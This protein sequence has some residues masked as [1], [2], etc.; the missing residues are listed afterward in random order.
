M[1]VGPMALPLLVRFA[2]VVRA[3]FLIAVCIAAMPL[4][5]QSRV[6]VDP[7]VRQ[8]LDDD[9]RA[10]FFILLP[11]AADLAAAPRQSGK[12]GKGQWVFETLRRHAQTAQSDLRSFL[13][14]HGVT[15][16][17]FLIAN[18]IHIQNG[19][20]A[21]V[22]ML[23]AR[24][25]IH[26]LLPDRSHRAERIVA[27]RESPQSTRGVEPN[28]KFIKVDQVWALGVEGSGIVLA[29]I[30][31]GMQWDH[32]A[33]REQYR[34]WNGHSADHN[35]HWWD[36]T[37]TYPLVPS[38]GVADGHGT[39]ITGTMVGRDRYGNQV[40]MAP[41]AKTIHCKAIAD[42]GLISEAWLLTCL[43]FMLAPWDLSGNAPRPDLAPDILGNSWGTTSAN[44]MFQQA[45][46]ALRSAG[47]LV[48]HSA[49]DLGPGCNSVDSPAGYGNVISTG[50][51]D[52]RNG[53][54]PG[55][56]SVFSS[57]GPSVLYP[58]AYFPSVVAPGEGIRSTYPGNGF[59]MR[60]GTGMAGA[61]VAGLAGL[62]W[63]ANPSLRGNIALTEQLI[64]DTAAPLTGQ[65][66][67]GCGGDYIDGPNHDWGHGAIDALA[68][69]QA[70][71]AIDGRPGTV[72][73]V[74]TDAG[75][76]APIS[77]ATVSLGTFEVQT[78]Q[79]GRYRL[80]RAPG[81]YA[82]T[83]RRG[84]YI[85]DGIDAL[86]IAS[87]ETVVHDLALQGA[88]LT[89]APSSMDQTVAPGAVMKRQMTL[90][91][92]GPAPLEFALRLRRGPGAGA[93]AVSLDA[94]EAWGLYTMPGTSAMTMFVQFLD[95]GRPDWWSDH[96]ALYGRYLGGT[97]A[98]PNLTWFY[99]MAS[100]DRLRLIHV[101]TSTVTDV[102]TAVPLGQNA[103]WTSLS[104]SPN[105][106]LY[107]LAVSQPNGIGMSTLYT[108]SA[109]DGSASRVGDIPASELTGMAFDADGTL[110]A[111]G[112]GRL[113][114][115]DP[116]TA[117]ATL[118]GPIGTTPHHGHGPLAVNQ[119][120]GQ[121]YQAAY[122]D[123]GRLLALDKATGEATYAGSLPR[124]AKF[125]AISFA[126]DG[127]G[128][129]A[130][131][132]PRTGTIPPGG[133]TTV[134]VRLDATRVPHASIYWATLNAEGA[135]ANTPTPIPL[136]MR[137]GC[138]AC[139]TVGGRVTDATTGH[140]VVASLH[141]DD[142]TTSLTTIGS[143]YAVN[144]P[145]G[146]YAVVATAAGYVHHNGMATI[147]MGDS[148]T[149]DIPLV[150]AERLFADG[151]DSTPPH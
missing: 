36:A 67:S 33:L 41:R 26:A 13:D 85:D 80:T 95:I 109:G 127:I 8:A 35:H 44:P 37:G 130:S 46:A 16:R 96:F 123:S 68:A 11:A 58:S 51:V 107:A 149:T 91:N 34:G 148:S 135:F 57:R 114:T 69:V 10:N 62:M 146:N 27:D 88:A 101:P 23:S 74:V 151:F 14:T 21:L 17:P 126:N 84:G 142:G 19:D 65:T 120:T 110:Y 141:F 24:T 81:T 140:P 125:E 52:H 115:L 70:A 118:I 119:A 43:E 2:W 82:L 93:A 55:V 20:A 94:G 45:I 48:E 63:Q 121:L 66:G 47:I 60:S 76:G 102:G 108:L 137:I 6:T 103:R 138:T 28:L 61:H 12:H 4:I 122:M 106:T 42:D 72:E 7:Q 117:R 25:D 49:G 40:G 77:G 104:A 129:W 133:T 147:M 83:V 124:D 98:G 111:S 143:S 132:T 150:R 100:P 64:Y 73:G 39:H 22:D 128:A 30:D 131:V 18:A 87:G 134:E 15:H 99:A 31:S 89:Y 9:G 144:L 53:P 5:A 1:T 136:T 59:G 105:G 71:I 145:A 29:A 86:P 38:E 90:T 139:G 75:S 79:T 97:L 113:Y 3:L 78:D 54:F 56:I 50:S 92:T 112:E 32:P 116:A